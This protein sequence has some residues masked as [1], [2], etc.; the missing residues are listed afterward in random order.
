MGFPFV[1]LDFLQLR[2]YCL[3]HNSP[4][5]DYAAGVF[6]V[7]NTPFACGDKFEAWAIPC[8]KFGSVRVTQQTIKH[9][10][11]SAECPSASNL[12]V[13][14]KWA[15]QVPKFL[16]PATLLA[17]QVLKSVSD[18]FARYKSMIVDKW[19]E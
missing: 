2:E 15:L 19:I 1:N 6:V 13:L 8:V 18:T 12:L 9:F 10:S 17:N 3:C 16:V 5:T 11:R 14:M 4:V 7:E